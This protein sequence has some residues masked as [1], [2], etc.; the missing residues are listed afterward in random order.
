[1]KKILIIVAIIAVVVGIFTAGFFAR[2][3][4]DDR[5]YS[6]STET[7]KA[8]VAHLTSG[9][10]A[11]AYAMTTKAYHDREDQKTFEA[12]VGQLKTDKPDAQKAKIVEN[13]DTVT[14]YQRVQNLPPTKNGNTTGD[15]YLTITKEQ[16]D[17][18]VASV[19]VQ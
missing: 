11:A 4:Y 1:M 18:K 15:F 6:G 16:G 14:Y 7:G 19:T 17:W 10:N 2:P 5:K 12:A 3:V 8:F 9:D 13:G